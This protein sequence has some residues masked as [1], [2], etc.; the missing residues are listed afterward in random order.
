MG[1]EGRMIGAVER[2][3]ESVDAVKRKIDLAELIGRDIA[4]VATGSVLKGSSPQRRDS[5]PSCGRIRRR[6]ATS[7]GRVVRVAIASTT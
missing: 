2:S 5:D 6:G 1:L 7:P 3:R 4:L